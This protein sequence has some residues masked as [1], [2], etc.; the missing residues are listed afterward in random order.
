M[1]EIKTLYGIYVP[2]HERDEARRIARMLYKQ[3]GDEHIAYIS[4]KAVADYWSEK[5]PELQMINEL[6]KTQNRVYLEQTN[7]YRREL[8]ELKALKD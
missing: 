7:A 1:M 6:L 3:L 5:G 2:R 8:E 4:A